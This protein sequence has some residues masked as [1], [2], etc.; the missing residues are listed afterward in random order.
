MTRKLVCSFLFGFQILL[1]M[2]VA[3]STADAQSSPQIFEVIAPPICQNSRGEIVRFET[4]TSQTAK[5]AAGMAKNDDNGK[6][7]IYRFSYERSPAALQ[8]FV[9]MHECAHHQTGDIDLP[10]PPRNSPAHMMNESIADCIATL[11]IRDEIDNGASRIND[12]AQALAS[13]MAVVGFPKITI[14][15]RLSNINN[16]RLK[17]TT[18][19]DFING[20]LAHRGLK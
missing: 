17:D 1:I 11:R 20:V 6:P 18:A 14:D 16:C 2:L 7:V 15:S 10:H 9:D 13:A 8:K 19:D 4:R 3:I 12:A 5:S